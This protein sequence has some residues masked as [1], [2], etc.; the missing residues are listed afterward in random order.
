MGGGMADLTH[1]QQTRMIWI[2]AR[3]VGAGRL[4]RADI[5]AA[6]GLGVGQA[7]RDIRMYDQLHPGRLRYDRRAKTYHANRGTLPAYPADLRLTVVHAVEAV[8]QVLEA[9]HG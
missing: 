4:N 6:F 8:A 1:A 3:L 7:V 9:K 5:I 2:D